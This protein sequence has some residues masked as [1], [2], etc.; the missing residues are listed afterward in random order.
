M[1]MTAGKLQKRLHGLINSNGSRVQFE[2]RCGLYRLPALALSQSY[3]TLLH[4]R[5]RGQRF[6]TENTLENVFIRFSCP[7]QQQNER[8]T[9]EHQSGTN[10]K[11]CALRP[12]QRRMSNRNRKQMHIMCFHPLLPLWHKLHKQ[13]DSGCIPH[14]MT[15]SV[16]QVGRQHLRRHAQKCLENHPSS[17]QM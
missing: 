6:H 15:A 10:E 1:I 4:R 17:G 12:G 2:T 13:C 3:C 16:L 11:L 8:T 7:A 14:M 5:Q 9:V